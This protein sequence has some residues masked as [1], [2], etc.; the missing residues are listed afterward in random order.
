MA[1]ILGEQDLGGVGP[2][3]EGGAP[4]P[5]FISFQDNK[6]IPNHSRWAGEEMRDQS[7]IGQKDKV[8]SN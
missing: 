1:A 8:L 2:R 7:L 6:V 5:I 3:G 4:C